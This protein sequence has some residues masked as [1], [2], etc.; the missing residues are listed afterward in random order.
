M[1]NFSTKQ[2]ISPAKKLIFNVIAISIP[3]I[4]LLFLELF[5]RVVHYGHNF[6]LVADYGPDARYYTMNSDASIKYFSNDETATKGLVEVFEKQKTQNT[7]RI[8]VLGE[9]TTI[10]FP[11]GR[12][13]SFHSWLKYR[14]SRSYP[15]KNFEV[16][17]FGLTAVNSFTALGFAEQL[18]Q[19]KPDA[20]L[21][22]LGHNEY[23]GALGVGSTSNIG[24]NVHL[25]R[26]L[27][28]LREFKTVQLLT[29]FI[30]KISTLTK[31]S[32]VAQKKGEDLSL[33]KKM[34]ANQEIE[35]NSD[36]YKIGVIQFET[37]LNDICKV[38][39]DSNIPTFVSNLVS[40]EK[41]LPPMNGL[42]E[43]NDNIAVQSFSLANEAM[44]REDFKRAKALFV[45]A[46]NNDKLRFRAP[47]EFNSIIK[48]TVVKYKGVHF[49]D[50]YSLFEQN[51]PYG[52]LGKE[53]I[54]E[55]VHP[56]L[57]G[58]ALISDA[59]FTS[60]KREQ[61]IVDSVHQTMSF[62]ELLRSMPVTAIDSL[63][64]E[65][66]VLYMKEDWPYNIPIPADFK[67]DDTFESKMA[68]DIV[69]KKTPP[70]QLY[71]SIS[72]Y[73][74]HSKNF[75]VWGKL[76]EATYLMPPFEPSVPLAT[77]KCYFTLGDDVLGGFYL[78]KAF[79]VNPDIEMAKKGLDVYLSLDMPERVMPFVDFLEQ[80]NTEYTKIKT[81]VSSLVFLKSQLKKNIDKK[82]L[83]LQIGQFYSILGKPEMALKY[84]FVKK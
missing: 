17:N 16:I 14:L 33:M 69:F 22:Y 10:G 18:A 25:I 68:L 44:K 62:D 39:S 3:F 29:N 24:S 71:D 35:F 54:L 73:Y 26:F 65:Y 57:K 21:V 2:N 23:V 38:L 7:I 53:L 6:D 36:E 42:N 78:T 63:R 59:F 77:A 13:G 47:F 43:N 81:I 82:D 56:N 30:H 51:S 20:V 27:I 32:V 67:F 31:P 66:V 64:G 45:D 48:K 40:N 72:D 1:D 15:D 61:V 58:Y 11:Y 28:S 84:G 74:L 79:L 55:H 76:L 12:I 46:L 37:N 49:V 52:I 9:S 60:M 80:R 41:D 19:Y 8:F 70:V 4:L 75:K 83:S 50:C 34:V 5:L